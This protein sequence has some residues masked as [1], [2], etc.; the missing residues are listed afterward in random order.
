MKKSILI[1]SFLCLTVSCF[2]Q[3]AK[4][5]ENDLEQKKE[6]IDKL[7]KSANEAGFF[8][9]N[10]LV[11]EN[12]KI[13]YK[14]S[15]GYTD[16]TNTTKLTADYRFHLG[17]ITKEFSA[18]ALLQL[19][20]QGK[21]KLSDN[22]SKF[23]PELPNWAKEVTIKD[24]LQ[25]TSGIP[26]VKWKTIKNDKDIFNDLLLIDTLSFKPGTDYD[27]NNNNLFLR[28]FIIEHLTGIPFKTYAEKFIFQP[29][30][31]NSTLMTPFQNEKNIAKGF[32]NK[33]INDAVEVP[34]TGGTYTTTD[35]LLL[36]ADNL[37]SKKNVNKNSL[38]V[39]GQSYN[40]ADRQSAL[41][42]AK[43]KNKNLMEHI[44]DGRAGNFEAILF[45]D[46]EKE[47]T[48]ILLCNNYN[49]KLFKISDTMN[50]ILNNREF[51][52]PKK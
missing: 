34:I 10:V 1:V 33:L 18:V 16:A 20:E 49:G 37:H 7:M 39:L 14:G 24:L 44:H 48:I 30:Q 4:N 21:L 45:S 15:F 17:S 6:T 2:S 5:S 26:N 22:V 29:L 50:A 28:Q 23:I 12:N 38:F 36:W 32:N 27:Y 19:E 31:M 52:F 8:N 35:D 41:G 11:S 42:K 46:I 3:K 25:Y 47:I 9:G 43:F 51:N 40:G 13:I